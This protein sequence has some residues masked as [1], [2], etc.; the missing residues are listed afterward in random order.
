MGQC[1]EPVVPVDESCDGLDNDCDGTTDEGSA[2]LDDDGVADCIDDDTD[3]DG[4]PNVDDNCQR[5]Q[6][7]QT[8][9]D[10]DGF[11]VCDEDADGDGFDRESIVTIKLSDV[12]PVHKCV[13]RLMMTVT[14]KWTR[15]WRC[16]VTMAQRRPPMLACVV[17]VKVSV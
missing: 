7:E 10:L 6:S 3:G 5:Y 14:A 16:V 2:D 12:I 17:T 15:R 8:D 9:L 4:V 13:M 1:D 11:D